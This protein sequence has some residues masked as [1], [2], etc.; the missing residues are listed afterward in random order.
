MAR[1]PFVKNQSAAKWWGFGLFLVG[2]FLLY[3]A[4]ERRG[5]STPRWLRPIT[6]W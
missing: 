6:F 3:D 5:V 2:A 4:Y 1:R